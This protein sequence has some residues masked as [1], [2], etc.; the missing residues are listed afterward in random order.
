MQAADAE[1][2][3]LPTSET[4]PDRLGGVPLRE[5]AARL[6]HRLRQEDLTLSVAESCTAGGLADAIT[7]VP[8]A[9]E[10]FVGGIIAYANRVKCALLGVP[11]SL[12]TEQGAV[13]A[14]VAER[15]ADG[16]RKS[17]GT[18]LAAS[19]T[20]IAGPDGGTPAKPVGLVYIGLATR[21]GT[22][23]RRF[24]FAGSRA[25]IRLSAIEATLRWLQSTVDTI[26]AR[27]N[28]ETAP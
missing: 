3:G 20:G 10:Y 13:S 4:L 25:T 7:S 18:S 2:R 16:C 12:L 23:S 1:V 9:S 19:I 8:G 26:E 27:H 15:M 14:A 28:G 24:L 5:I 22:R 17:F 11:E 6:G 21:S